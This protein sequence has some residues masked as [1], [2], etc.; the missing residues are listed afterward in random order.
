MACCGEGFI[1]DHGVSAFVPEM[2]NVP[3]LTT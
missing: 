1:P 2:L 3:G